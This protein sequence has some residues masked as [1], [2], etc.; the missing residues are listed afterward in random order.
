MENTLQILSS[1]SISLLVALANGGL[2][3][4][5]LNWMQITILFFISLRNHHILTV[6]GWVMGP[7][8]PCS[9]QP[10]SG[11]TARVPQVTPPATSGAATQKR[12]VPKRAKF[13]SKK[14]L[15]GS[16]TVETPMFGGLIHVNTTVSLR[17]FCPEKN[18]P[19]I[20]EFRPQNRPERCFGE[21]KLVET[22][23]I[24]W[25]NVEFTL[26]KWGIQGWLMVLTSFKMFNCL[27]IFLH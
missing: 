16:F 17:T 14:W 25:R 3:Q 1:K 24:P 19:L 5:S 8:P 6:T 12:V 18:N 21:L 10:N 20:Y 11:C 13:P 4:P 27:T 26:K 7:W 2:S 15:K 23:S 9:P 22:N